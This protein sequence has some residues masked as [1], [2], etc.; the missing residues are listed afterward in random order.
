MEDMIPDFPARSDDHAALYA[1]CGEGVGICTIVG[2]EGSFSRRLGAQLA[3]LPDGSLIGSLADGCL[4][5][6]LASDMETAMSA[7]R[8][9]IKRFGR[10]SETIDFRLPCGSGLD[11]L[12]DPRPDRDEFRR[13]V[14]AL[15]KREPATVDLFKGRESP[16]GML[17]QRSYMPALEILLF[18]EGPELSELAS[19]CHHCG[20]KA[21]TFD[22]TS[23][24]DGLALGQP[25]AD[26]HADRW[27]AIALLFHDHEWERGLLEWALGTQSYY[28]GAIGGTKTR[29]ERKQRLLVAGFDDQ[30]VARIESPIGTVHHSREPMQLALSVMADMTGRYEKLHPHA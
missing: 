22:R 23:P 27:T 6:Q 14:A 24:V 3:V 17:S 11:I 2:I 20:C 4:E 1:A 9:E 28:I 5:R 7:G 30:A 19:L 26:L 8:A 13:A 10:G 16:A 12:I 21:R 15:K 29:E 18:G 25:P